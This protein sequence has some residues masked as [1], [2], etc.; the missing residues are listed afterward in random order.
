MRVKSHRWLNCH[1]DN[2]TFQ[3]GSCVTWPGLR[4]SGFNSESTL[5][6]LDSKTRCRDSYSQTAA[7]LSWQEQQRFSVCSGQQNPCTIR[8]R[9]SKDPWFLAASLHLDSHPWINENIRTRGCPEQ[10]LEPVRAPN[11]HLIT[12]VNIIPCIFCSLLT[13]FYLHLTLKWR[14]REQQL[15]SCDFCFSLLFFFAIARVKVYEMIPWF[16]CNV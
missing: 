8:A 14:R 2:M 12:D 11:F 1:R 7:V 10:A 16:I 4:L 13:F 15:K 6:I 3:N 5:L 9:C